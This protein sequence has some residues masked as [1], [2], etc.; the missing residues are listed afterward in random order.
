MIDRAALT[1]NI[2]IGM[3]V[4][5]LIGSAVHALALAEDNP[6]LV[7]G[8]NGLIDIG[9]YRVRAIPRDSR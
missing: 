3:V 6:L 9:D 4:G 2:L 7:Y 8:V 1:R 5:L